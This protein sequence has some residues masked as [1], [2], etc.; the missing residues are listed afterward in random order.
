[1]RGL[2]GVCAKTP[3]KGS[4]ERARV[5]PATVAALPSHAKYIIIIIYL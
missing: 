4:A 5:K 3:A 1:M 2:A